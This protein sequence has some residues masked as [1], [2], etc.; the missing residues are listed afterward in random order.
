MVAA[1]AF[2]ERAK[3]RFL[4]L[5]EWRKSASDQPDRRGLML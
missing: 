4:D 5:A 2:T 3:I 1:S